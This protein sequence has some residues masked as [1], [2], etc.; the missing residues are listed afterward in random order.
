MSIEREEE[1]LPTGEEQMLR[2]PGRKDNDAKSIPSFLKRARIRR[3]LLLVMLAA[4]FING[5]YNQNYPF[6]LIY[7]GFMVV[8]L[9]VDDSLL[10]S[11]IFATGLFSA[12]SSCLSEIP[13]FPVFLTLLTLAIAIISHVVYLIQ[14]ICR[15]KEKKIWAKHFIKVCLVYFLLI[16]LTCSENKIELAGFSAAVHIM[17]PALLRQVPPSSGS[18]RYHEF[19][20]GRFGCSYV[21]VIYDESDQIFLPSNERSAEWREVS[22]WDRL[23]RGDG[24]EGVCDSLKKLYSHFY[25]RSA[26]CR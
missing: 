7:L 21:T 26:Y 20:F 22:G 24:G 13:F 8:G 1:T 5:I 10:L 18:F 15:E 2:N 9:I 11:V 25:L 14:K 6:T 3:A 4:A 19:K 16:L 17:E 23:G 12:M